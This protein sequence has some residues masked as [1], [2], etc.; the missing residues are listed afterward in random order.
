MIKRYLIELK[1]IIRFQIN[2]EI[3][4]SKKYSECEVVYEEYFDDI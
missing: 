2:K 4:T 1:G 3:N